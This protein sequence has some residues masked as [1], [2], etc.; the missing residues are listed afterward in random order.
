[1]LDEHPAYRVLIVGHA[2]TSGAS[3]RNRDLCYRRARS[4]R[5]I[6]LSH[7]VTEAR[8][9]IAAALNAAVWHLNR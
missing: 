9:T 4:V 7:G 5:K 8:V 3:D 6:L 1:M 2:D